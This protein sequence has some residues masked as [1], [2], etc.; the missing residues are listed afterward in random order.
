MFGDRIGE[1]PLDFPC[2]SV[3]N[4]PMCAL[5]LQTRAQAI[6][7]IAEH[8]LYGMITMATYDWLR[9][10]VEDSPWRSHST[11]RFRRVIFG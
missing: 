9:E 4:W 5:A 11:R 7:P 2:F 3:L 1:A 6:A 10:R 8:A